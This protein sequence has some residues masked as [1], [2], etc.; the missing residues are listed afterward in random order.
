[1]SRTN[2]DLN[3]RNRAMTRDLESGTDPEQVATKY[4]LSLPYIRSILRREGNDH[5]LD[6]AK[7]RLRTK[8]ENV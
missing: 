6:G 1:M 7:P 5:L 4:N 8:R 2:I 3:E